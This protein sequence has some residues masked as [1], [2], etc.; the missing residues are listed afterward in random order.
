MAS[1]KGDHA[2]NLRCRPAPGKPGRWTSAPP[3]ATPAAMTADPAS[4]RDV[5]GLPATV[6]AALR[7][8]GEALARFRLDVP[9]G[10]RL[11]PLW[12]EALQLMKRLPA[13]A[14]QEPRR[15][16]LAPFAPLG[17][18]GD[19]AAAAG[20]LAAPEATLAEI[21]A[22]R[23]LVM[24]DCANEGRPLI[25]RH[26][27]NL[28]AAIDGA[29]VPP[30]RVL[31]VQQN[32]ALVPAY[33]AACAARGR[34]PMRVVVAHSHAA[35]LWSRLML[36][37]ARTNW[38]F[39]FAVAHD[40]PRRHRWVCLNY[41]LRPHRALLVAWLVER[42]EP[43]FLSFSATRETHGRSAT[44]R[45]LSGAAELDRADP[46]GARASVARLLESGLHHGSDIDG[47]GHPSERIYSLP[48]GE[49]AA[50]EL[51]IVTETE[52][53][54]P[55]LLRWTEKT[56]KALGSGLPFVVFGNPGVVGALAG[57]GFDMLGDIVDHGYDSEP[58]PARRFAA[59]RAA[60]ARFLARPP[61]FSAPEMARLRDA[62]AHNRGVF[63]RVLLQDALLDPLDA[64]LA[65]AQG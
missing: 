46:D 56:L 4:P 24:V 48:A 43:G 26:M 14:P 62:A 9:P 21:R 59:A 7:R 58:E 16:I 45:L 13:V 12:H 51:F 32:R 34:A 65:A 55:G 64:I 28:H 2:H 57:L 54:G 41:N 50:A 40:G 49:V 11:G 10:H 23:G 47:F 39:G 6:A 44:A 20:L 15:P 61:G 52:M 17:V 22:G 31:W 30:G 60:V 8:Q 18:L 25:G 19:G 5:A 37:R 1:E 53:L 33:E 3:A 63:A 35:G 42:P 38:R 27:E 36:G 29:G